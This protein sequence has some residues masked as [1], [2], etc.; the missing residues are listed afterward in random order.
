MRN[1]WKKLLIITRRECNKISISFLKAINVILFFLILFIFFLTISLTST[2]LSLN[3]N[4]QVMP[5][6]GWV[7]DN[8]IKYF[9]SS[10]TRANPTLYL[11]SLSLILNSLIVLLSIA[12][13]ILPVYSIISYK[14]E[15]DRKNFFKPN[16]LFQKDD[17]LRIMLKH[18]TGAQKVIIRSGDF[19]WINQND[20]LKELI[21]QL[22]LDGHLTLIS[23]KT[24]D[25]IIAKIGDPIIYQ[26]LQS[27]LNFNGPKGVKC[28]YIYRNGC[29][30]FLYKYTDHEYDDYQDFILDIKESTKTRYLLFLLEKLMEI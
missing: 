2:Y 17:D 29:S 24:K 22:A 7:S 28:S 4:S 3:S 6:Y 15:M 10:V 5:L 25:E 11:S 26:T 8:V 13:A 12:L 23:Y 19:S 21:L 9:S 18:Y 14:I 20:E 16:Q 1:G 27:C 30:E